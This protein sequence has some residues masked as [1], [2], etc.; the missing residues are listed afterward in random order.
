MTV[1]HI[2][3]NNGCC[4]LIDRMR[5][6]RGHMVFRH[7][8]SLKGCRNYDYGHNFGGTVFRSL[9]NIGIVDQQMKA[10]LSIAL[11]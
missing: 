1:D 10:V 9:T 8:G 6:F 7:N 11:F 5:V 3:L 4:D 2:A